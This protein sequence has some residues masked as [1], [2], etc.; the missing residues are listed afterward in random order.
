MPVDGWSC[1]AELGGDLGRGVTA[2][3]ICVE[4]G[5]HRRRQCDL[6][7]AQTGLQ[8][9]AIGMLPTSLSRPTRIWRRL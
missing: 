5:V 2:V 8:R 7:L 1:D 9:T 6:T 3:A 4:F